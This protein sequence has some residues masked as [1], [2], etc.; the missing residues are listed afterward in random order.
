MKAQ[1]API[2]LDRR[3]LLVYSVNLVRQSRNYDRAV[4]Q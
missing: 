4:S 2:R 3:G 1:K